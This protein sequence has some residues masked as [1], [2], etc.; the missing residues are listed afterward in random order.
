MNDKPLRLGRLVLCYPCALSKI[1]GVLW[2][3][4]VKN[5]MK[6]ADID[7]DFFHTKLFSYSK[8][9]YCLD[10]HNS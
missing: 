8:C 10:T 1:S 5:G 6:K 4:I 3:R 9:V 2:L 7:A